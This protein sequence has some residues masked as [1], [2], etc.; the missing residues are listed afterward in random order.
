MRSTWTF[1]AR[2]TL[3]RMRI[4]SYSQPVGVATEF[5]HT[6]LHSARAR[7]ILT[8]K[9]R[10]ARPGSDQGSDLLGSVA[11]PQRRFDRKSG[12]M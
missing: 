8:A 4:S 6:Q 1:A 10:A 9:A 12:R 11:I 3:L 5:A 7:V 2:G